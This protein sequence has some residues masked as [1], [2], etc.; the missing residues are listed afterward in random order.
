[1]KK[2]WNH[3]VNSLLTGVLVLLGFSSCTNDDDEDNGGN[4]I[5]EY[6][7]PT[8]RHEIKGKVV[9]T[10]EQSIQNIQVIVT[11]AKGSYAWK[12][13][14]LTTDAKGEFTFE[15]GG[16]SPVT[17]YKVIWNDLDGEANGG[18]FKSDSIDV[19]TVKTEDGSGWY[20]GKGTANVKIV[21]KKDQTEPK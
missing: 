19:E 8:A 6:G 7:S 2:K 1:M 17:K 14:T 10:E 3:L 15:G 5:L 13:D 4:I 21:L 18:L 12:T 16:G 20:R 11:P 9:N